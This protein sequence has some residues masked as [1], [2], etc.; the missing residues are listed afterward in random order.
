MNVPSENMLKSNTEL[1]QMVREQYKELAN[2][3]REKSIREQAAYNRE[4][5]EY[6]TNYQKYIAEKLNASKNKSDFLQSV[7]EAFLTECIMKLYRQSVPTPM[8]K[9]DNTIARNLV[10]RFVK[11]NGVGD[12]LIDFSTKNVLLSEMARITKKYYNKVLE[13]CSPNYDMDQRP[14]GVAPGE[15]MDYKL[16]TTIRDDFFKELE[17]LECA[18]A[19]NMIKDRVADSITEFI[20]SNAAAKMEYQDIIDQAQDKIAALK[21]TGDASLDEALIEEQ[22]RIAKSKINDLKIKRKKNVFNIMV[23]SLTRK[24]L[25]DNAFKE[26]FVHESSVD[27]DAIV[28]STTLI[29]TMLEMVNTTRMVNVNEAFITEYL[30]SLT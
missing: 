18:D 5:E 13:D 8:T 21:P 16:S 15:V 30:Q 6:Q 7:K 12:L 4:V 17:D 28:D 11:E 26:Q 14:D 2:E 3:E 19:A 1:A 22:S 9:E 27:M 23:E 10:T 25:T 24:A 20:D 29:Y